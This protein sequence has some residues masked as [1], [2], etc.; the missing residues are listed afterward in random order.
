MAL[1]WEALISA[2]A[3]ASAHRLLLMLFCFFEASSS[4]CADMADMFF[5]G[6][7][8][9][10]CVFIASSDPF[11][12]RAHT[13]QEIAVNS[14]RFLMIVFIESAV[15]VPLYYERSVPEAAF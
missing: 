5:A 8:A 9:D 10:D 15:W 14:S 4:C 12:A 1:A 11:C 13:E 7:G 2:L 6:D 3:I